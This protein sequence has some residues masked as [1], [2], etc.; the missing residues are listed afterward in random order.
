MLEFGYFLFGSV[1]TLL[2]SVFFFVRSGEQL[3][4]EAEMLRKELQELRTLQE[5]TIYAL[6]NPNADLQPKRDRAGNVIGLIVSATG[7]MRAMV[8]A[9]AVLTLTPT[10]EA[11]NN[12]VTN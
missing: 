2:V 5:L 4:R 7:S 3:K 9:K 8:T 12:K 6:T 1:I 11:P 10:P